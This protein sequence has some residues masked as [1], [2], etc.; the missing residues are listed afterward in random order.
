MMDTPICST[1]TPHT[2]LPHPVNKRKKICARNVSEVRRSNRLADLNAGF[3][4]KAAAD[5]AAG[6]DTMKEKTVAKKSTKT[7]NKQP[8]KAHNVSFTAE[9]MDS[10]APPLHELPLSTVQAIGV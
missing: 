8:K 7:S 9:V 6:K 3:K 4:D 1:E 10:S 2:E 5:I